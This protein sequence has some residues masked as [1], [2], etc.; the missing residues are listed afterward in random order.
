MHHLIPSMRHKQP[1]GLPE[2]Q[3]LIYAF[4]REHPV[5]VLTS[6]DPN[7]YPHGAVIY[8]YVDKHFSISF[9]TKKGTKKYDNLVRNG[10][11][12][13]VVYEPLSQSVAQVIG[14]AEE[15]K[16]DYD[17]NAM[18]QHIFE[19]SMKTSEGGVPP[20]VKLEAG[21]Y[22]GFSIQP[23]QIRMAVYERPDSGDYTQL[24]E[25]IESFE[26]KQDAVF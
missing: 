13:L 21:E 17:V 16:D 15:M 19:A 14:E 1:T 11:I 18:A 24:F 9:L 20:I 5:G 26:L 2:R 6:V 4:L 10:K 8:Y 7:G 12:M 25:S 3:W 23:Y 22:A